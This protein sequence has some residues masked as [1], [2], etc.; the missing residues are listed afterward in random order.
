MNNP[1]PEKK[2]ILVLG[3]YY[4]SKEVKSFLWNNL[5]SDLNLADF[6]VVIMDLTKFD[7]NNFIQSLPNKDLF[8]DTNFDNFLFGLNNE[9]II[10]GYPYY[11]QKIVDDREQIFWFGRLFPFYPRFTDAKGEGIQEISTEYEYLFKNIERWNKHLESNMLSYDF[12]VQS[13]PEYITKNYKRI[14]R[15]NCFINITPIAK[16]LTTHPI[17]FSFYLSFVFTQHIGGQVRIV[18]LKTAKITNLPP[19]TNLSIEEAI[20]KFWSINLGQF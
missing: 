20:K 6:E 13:I 10:I 16:M 7:E 9:L 11:Y 1:I 8:H 3:A 14:E 5:P 17:A 18:P 2:K 15:P 12:E 4:K 19:T